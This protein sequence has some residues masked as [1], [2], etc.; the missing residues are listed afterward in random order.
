M[1]NLLTC[2]PASATITE[3]FRITA[4]LTDKRCIFLRTGFVN[5]RLHRTSLGGQYATLLIWNNQMPC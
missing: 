3:G 1:V 2:S 5:I 4:F